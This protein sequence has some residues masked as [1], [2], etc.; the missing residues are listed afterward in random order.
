M[1]RPGRAA[2]GRGGYDYFPPISDDPAF[3]SLG[4][5]HPL[6]PP[7]PLP[8]S[9]GA[10]PLAVQGRGILK[11]PV[12]ARGY[13]GRGWGGWGQKNVTKEDLDADLDEWRLTDKRL[14]GQS[15]DAELDDYWRKKESTEESKADVFKRTEDTEDLAR[16]ETQKELDLYP[17]EPVTVKDTEPIEG[18]N[19]ECRT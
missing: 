11:R 15:L 8:R 1:Q 7:P 14:A 10:A 9:K 2:G 16:S 3:W 19:I 13:G 12:Y 5:P 18:V 4:F 17:E 6:P